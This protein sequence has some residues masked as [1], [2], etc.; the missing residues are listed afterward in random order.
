MAGSLHARWFAVYVEPPR[1]RQLPKGAQARLSQNLRLAEQ[2]GG[3]A[4]TLSGENPS[5][6]LLR[7]ARQH[8]IN[9]IILGKPVASRLRDRFR[10]SLVDQMVRLSGDID[11]YVT[12]GDPERLESLPQ[13][14]P[15][16][17][18]Q[19]SS[20][21]AAAGVTL[22]T[23]WVAW[24]LFGRD[25][26]PD[27]VMVYL[28]G[29]IL[30]SARSTLG[31][32]VAS[33][34]LSVA[35]FDFVF[36]PP[37]LTF[38]VGDFRHVVTFVVMFVVAVVISGL[39]Q[40]IRNQASAAREREGRTAALYALSRE[41]TA[42]QGSARVREIAGGHLER[43]FNSRVAVFTPGLGGRL[44]RTYATPE[45]GE[46]S[47]RDTSVSEWVWSNRQEAGIGTRT[48][49]GGTA[50]NVPLMAA[51]GIVG[52]LSLSPEQPERFD[53]LEQ[54]RLVDAFAA[55]LAMA[56][57]RAELAEQTEKAR[58][59]VEAE[60]LRSSLLSSVSHD[61][62]T[63]LA[64]IT[65]SAST[66]LENNPGVD[67][68]TRRDLMQT[69][70][71]EAERL[72]RL[73]RNLLDMTRLESGAVKVKKEWL[74]LEEVVGSALER[75]DA[76]LVNREVS[77]DLPAD[78]PLVP[79]DAL[80]VEL[81]LINL[82]ENAAKY[83]EAKIELKATLLSGEV[84]VEVNDRGSG[85]PRDQELRVFEKF[86][87]AVREGSPGGVGL[88]LAI[89]RAVVAVHGGRIWAQNR[90][91]GGASFRFTLPIEGEP[92]KL[93]DAEALES[94]QGSELPP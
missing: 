66:L 39:T 49:P 90:E 48:L 27:V 86:H 65:G 37:Y 89:S 64:V 40:R 1:A 70:L 33:A 2:L 34:F 60:Q 94:E 7:F 29:I 93:T 88:G 83:S 55:Q 61:L 23:T 79:C 91:G 46:V 54:R 21:A 18:P 32:S 25:Q 87:R 14:Q 62:R 76:R 11:V 45:L 10:S 22:V 58:R 44:Q 57:E 19:V 52:V 50:L 17:S 28:L 35:A 77:I 71:E 24:L 6:E 69:I 74:P 47:D 3:E 5:E 12:A 81:L 63:P 72:N 43:V 51:G 80:L 16:P 78:L 73:I 41:L 53:D 92:P 42:A 38:A 13:K 20:F 84:L 36:V 26:L 4:V 8:N 68:G 67:A 30:V 59:E 56:M 15:L 82:L 85:I 75:L 9:K 31:A